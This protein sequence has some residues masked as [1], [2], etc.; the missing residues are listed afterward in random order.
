MQFEVKAYRTAEGLQLLRVAASSLDEAG[1][2]LEAQGYRVVGARSVRAF[3]RPA[4]S[5]PFSRRFSLSLF[6][7]ELLALLDAGLGITE[8][9][10][11]LARKARGEEAKRILE[12]LSRALREG[13]ALS[14]ALE[15]RPEAFPPLFVAAIRSSERTGNVQDALR[16][17]LDYQERVN[18]VRDKIVSASIYPALLLLVGGLVV[19]FLLGYV[20]PRFSSVYEEVGNNVTGLSRALIAWG[21]FLGAYAGPVAAG[22]LG[23]LIGVVVLLRT[24]GFKAALTRKAWT[25]PGLGEKLRLYQLARLCHTLGMLLQGGIPFVPALGL[26]AGL[27]RDPALTRGLAGARRMIEEGQPIS[28]AFEQHRLATEVG[29]RLLSVGERSGEM[30]RM[31]ERIARFY[32]D[33]L[34]RA[35]DWFLRLFEPLLMAFIGVAVGVIVLLMY[36]PI[37]ELASSLQ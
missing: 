26:A 19:V 37:F 17:Y 15:Q 20:V 2:I 3:S 11:A 28:A 12:G 7:Q 10:D 23:L 14:R 21:N 5:Q 30:G 31:M 32:D 24:V 36:L 25:L 9:L 27:L 33:E 1:R 16:R 35:M 4:F 29:V 22:L 18:R 8:A 6:A 34:E 13:M